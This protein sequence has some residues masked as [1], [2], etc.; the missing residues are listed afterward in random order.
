MPHKRAKRSAREQQRK[1]RGADL[2]PPGAGSS[3]TLSTEGIP[4]S[5]SRVLDAAK[6]RTEYRQKKRARQ[7]EEG[8]HDGDDGDSA[9]TL[10]KGKKRRRVAADSGAGKS[11]TIEIQPGESLKHFNRRVEDHMRPLVRSAMLASA[12]TERK[13]RKAVTVNGTPRE[14]KARSSVGKAEGTPSIAA[15]GD[16]H[17][18]RPKEFATISSARP[19]RL[20]DIATAP[21]ELKKLPRRRASDLGAKHARTKAVGSVLSMAQRAMMETE[22]ENAIRRY[23]E[24]K[25]RKAKDES[26]QA[27]TS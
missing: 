19:R 13:E 7:L 4:K 23:R 22:R 15:G 10:A 9:P 16:K 27:Q 1:E 24:M 2:A 25:E 18:D 14:S 26:D 21:P 5:I 8:T 17:R 6:I 3:T 11:S 12:A 20:N